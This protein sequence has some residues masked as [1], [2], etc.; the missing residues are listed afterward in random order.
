MYGKN[1]IPNI[2]Q[3][4]TSK[5]S[6]SGGIGVAKYFKFKNPSYP[7]KG[8]VGL[9]EKDTTCKNSTNAPPLNG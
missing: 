7:K 8:I 1:A 2:T 9:Y 4:A 5:N 3:N 6:R